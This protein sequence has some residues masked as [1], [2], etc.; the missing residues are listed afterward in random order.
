M[1]RKSIACVLTV[2]NEKTRNASREFYKDKKYKPLDLRVKKVPF[3][4]HPRFITRFTLFAQGD[5]RRSLLHSLVGVSVLKLLSNALRASVSTAALADCVRALRP[6]LRYVV[7]S[8][9]TSV[10]SSRAATS[11]FLCVCV[12][13]Y[14]SCTLVLDA[15]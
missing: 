15:M 1:V 7:A 12:C 3:T 10:R 14:S 8:A 9:A 11:F 5:T 2:M 4:P 6:R 13:M